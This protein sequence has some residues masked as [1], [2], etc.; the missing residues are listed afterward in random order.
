MLAR[1]IERHARLTAVLAVLIV[2]PLAA[3]ATAQYIGGDLTLEGPVTVTTDVIV[4]DDGTFAGDVEVD[5]NTTLGNNAGAD[6]IALTG[7]LTQ[8]GTATYGGAATFSSTVTVSGA[9]TASSTLTCAKGVTITPEATALPD[10]ATVES[11]GDGVILITAGGGSLCV[12]DDSN[13]T[14]QVFTTDGTKDAN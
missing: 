3:W 12:W 11:Y 14:F 1:W 4:G 6:A 10:T 2:A 7:V 8:S 5:G 13:K 9:A